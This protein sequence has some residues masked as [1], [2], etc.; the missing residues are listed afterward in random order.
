MNV[1][2]KL[3]S[4]TEL[5]HVT[6]SLSRWGTDACKLIAHVAAQSERIAALASELA[7]LR[8]EKKLKLERLSPT[9]RIPDP[10]PCEAH[11]QPWCECDK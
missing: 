9:M 1:E 3:M 2:P 8:E 6:E 11:G 7:A 5:L 4:A 10:E